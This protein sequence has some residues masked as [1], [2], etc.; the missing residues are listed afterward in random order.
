MR[1]VSAT[2]VVSEPLTL[3]W[4]VVTSGC[5]M[6]PW[7]ALWPTSPLKDAG[8]RIDPPPSDAVAKGRMPAATAAA[9]PPL[10]PPGV[11]EGSHALRVIPVTLFLVRLSVPNSG[12][13]VLPTG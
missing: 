1:A 7:L 4:F 12:E 3:V 8:M 13:V 11:R 6:R 5:G 2:V 10:E 9:E